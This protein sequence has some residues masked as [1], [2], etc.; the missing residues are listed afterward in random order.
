MSDQFTTLEGLDAGIEK[1]RSGAIALATKVKE[2]RA[3]MRDRL[4]SSG[5]D[6][7]ARELR[8]QLAELSADQAFSEEHLAALH[9]RRSAIAAEQAA[10]EAAAARAAKIAAF[11]ALVDRR[12]AI[13]ERAEAA[14]KALGKAATELSAVNTELKLAAP[15][16]ARHVNHADVK[17]GIS[18]SLYDGGVNFLEQSPHGRLDSQ[19]RDLAVHIA[20]RM[21]TTGA[22]ILALVAGVV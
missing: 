18:A 20:E 17:A 2:L 9:E 10:T 11:K 13:A 19:G 22:S 8:S 7:Q 6:K 4:L 16:L 15:A 21:A 12:N 14:A 1:A 3:K 5:T